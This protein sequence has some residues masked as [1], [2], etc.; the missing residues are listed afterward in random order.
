[1]SYPD[2]LTQQVKQIFAQADLEQKVLIFVHAR[3]K[4]SFVNGLK[5]ARARQSKPKGQQ[6]A[7]P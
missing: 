5:A 1:M 3:T 7:K 4:Q 6:T 2:E